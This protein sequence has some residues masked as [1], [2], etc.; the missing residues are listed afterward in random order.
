MHVLDFEPMWAPAN[1]SLSTTLPALLALAEKREAAGAPPQGAMLLRALAKGVEAQ[2]RLRLA[3]GQIEPTSITL[4]PPGAVGPLAAAAASAALLGLDADK[5][6]IAIGIAASR[7]GGML[8]NAGSMTKALHCGDAAAHGLEAAILA[9]RGFTADADAIGHYRGW[10]PSLFGDGFDPAPLTAPVETPRLLDPGPAWKL[11]P[12]QYGTHFVITAALEA[13][14]EVG[15]PA[16]IEAIELRVPEMP[17]IDRPSPATG[18]AGKFSWQY[19][20]CATLLDGRVDPS[21]FT[22]KRRFA[23]DMEG[24]LRRVRVTPDGAIPGRFDQMHVELTVRLADGR[25]VTRRCDAPAGNWRRKVGP[26]PVRLKARGLLAEVL[27]DA[28]ADGVLALL[29][30]PPDRLAIAQLMKPL[31]EGKPR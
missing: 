16:R 18:L 20:T 15:D 23:A 11:F 27:G 22:D 12:S 5:T 6:A 3:S 24:L 19:T 28:G 21:T 13:R 14:E 31:K 10:G 30:G 7:I 26:E 4:H 1:H 29:D 17:Y 25:I 2:G 8:A 9:E